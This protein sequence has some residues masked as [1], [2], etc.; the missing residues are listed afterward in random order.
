MDGGGRDGR[1]QRQRQDAPAEGRALSVNVHA[2]HVEL[3]SVTKLLA[4]AVLGH[5]R[6]DGG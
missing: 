4:P 3:E 1:Q 5:L 6:R 2:A